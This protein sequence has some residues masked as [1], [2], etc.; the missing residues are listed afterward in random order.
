LKTWRRRLSIRGRLLA[1]ALGAVVPLVL[2]GFAMLWVVWGAKEQQLNESL[3][4]QAE[5]SA[6]VFDRWLDAQR[7][8]LVT[9]ASYTAE[10]FR[11]A[12]ALEAD[13]RAAKAR[14]P[15]WIDVRILDAGGRVVAAYPS[16]AETLPAGLA[17]RLIA[18]AQSGEA[19]IETDWTRGE[20]RYVLALVSRASTG[21]LSETSSAASHY[22]NAHSSSP[23]L[24]RDAA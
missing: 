10:R 13:L 9:I 19:A 5:L 15:H 3:E 6:V 1:L 20:G 22:L 23:C 11:D 14:R 8:P 17:E 2:L 4:Q 12:A 24:I 16:N 7:Q 21:R 18:E